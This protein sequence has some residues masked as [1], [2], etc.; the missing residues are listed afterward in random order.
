M[1]QAEQFV[2]A[3][4]Q[5]L[6]ASKALRQRAVKETPATKDLGKKLGTKVTIHHTAKGGRLE[7]HFKNDT[8]LANLYKKLG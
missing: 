6:H 5:G 7:I 8:D 2:T 3:H 4:K 1:R